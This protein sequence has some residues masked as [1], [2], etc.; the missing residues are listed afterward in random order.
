MFKCVCS[1]IFGFRRPEKMV[2]DCKHNRD[3]LYFQTTSRTVA[4]RTSIYSDLVRIMLFDAIELSDMF[5]MF[6]FITCQVG[7]VG[8]VTDTGTPDSTR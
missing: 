7:G 1:V 8:Y 3:T 5:M 6:P 2:W 4:L